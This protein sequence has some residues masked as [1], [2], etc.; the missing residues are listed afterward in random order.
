[1]ISVP[2]LA[3]EMAPIYFFLLKQFF[4]IPFCWKIK[5]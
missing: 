2:Y 5:A 1:M 3:Q 4:T